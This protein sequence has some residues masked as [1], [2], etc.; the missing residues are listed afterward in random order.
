MTIMTIVWDMNPE[1]LPA[2][3]ENLPIHPRWYGLLFASG[4]LIGWKILQRIFKHENAP[5]KWIDS[6]FLYVMVGTILGA[7]LGHVFFYGWDYYSQ[8]PG[9]ILKIW[10]GGL[11]SHGAAIGNII[12]IGIWS[13]RVA[14]KNMLWTL[15]R[16]V[17]TIAL[18]GALIRLGNFMNS[19]IVGEPSDLP[20]A[21]LFVRNPQFGDVPRHPSQIYE[22]IA[23]LIIFVGLYWAYWKRNAG[24]YLGFL[25]GAFLTTIFGFRIFVEMVKENQEAFEEGMSLNMGQWLSIPLVLAGIYFMWRSRSRIIED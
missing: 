12:A 3:F 9:E 21:V 18:A 2:L 25:F 19:E 4:F 8:H 10:E 17:I 20:W 24:K 22:A 1:F 5:E 15:D 7:R 23:Y 14:K 13:K 6:I 11:A 16:V